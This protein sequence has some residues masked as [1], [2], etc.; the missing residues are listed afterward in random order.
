MI[1]S[2]QIGSQRESVFSNSQMVLNR[3]IMEADRCDCLIMW[4]DFK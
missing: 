1:N 2:S 4:E 3:V